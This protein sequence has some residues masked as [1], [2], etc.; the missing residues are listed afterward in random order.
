MCSQ[1]RKRALILAS[2][3]T[4]GLQSAVWA[5]VSI[6]SFTPGDLVVLRGGDTTNPST[7]PTTTL[8]AYLDEYTPAGVYQGTVG[9]PQAV[10]GSN[11][12]LTVTSG[13]GS[14]EGILTL[15][16][17]GNWLTFGGYNTP[18]T[19]AFSGAGVS[20]DTIAE[21]S[22]A[23]ATL[24]T[25]TTLGPATMRA[26]VTVDG[27]EFY[28][29]NAPGLQYVTGLGS[30][31]TTTAL[32]AAYNTRALLTVSNT[33][34]AGSGSSSLGTHGVWQLGSSGTLPTSG[35]PSKT[36]LTN[37]NIQDGTDFVF[38]DEPGD[39]LTNNLYQGKYNVM[40]SVG[41]ANGSATI[42]KYQ[43]DGTTFDLLNSETPVQGG[44][45]IL[46]GVTALV[47]GSNVNLYY[48][49]NSG[50]YKIVD[51]NSASTPLPNNG[52]LFYGAPAGQDFYGVALTP[53]A[54]AGSNS[55]T[56]NNTN[57]SGDGAT[58]NTTSQNWNNGTGVVAFSTSANVI[59]DDSSGLNHYTVNIASTG[60]TA[61]TITVNTNHS[62][63]YVFTG[64]G[65]IAGGQGLTLSAGTLTLA[66]TGVNTYGNTNVSAGR[67]NVESPTALPANSVLAVA[68]G[69]L[70]AVSRNGGA[71][72]VL[73]LNSLSNSGLIDLQNNDLI[74]HN[75]DTATAGATLSGVFNQLQAGYAGGTWNGT[76]GIVSSTAARSSLYTLGEATGTSGVDGTSV[77]TDVVVKY[78][79]YGDADLSGKIDSSD[80]TKIDN[81]YLSKLTGW[82]NGDFNYDG[83]VNGSDY[84]L[85]D[86]AF[87]SQGVSLA[88]QF[89]T[90]TSQI[91]GPVQTAVPEP[92][93]IGL[94][95]LMGTGA[96]ARRRTRC[97]LPGQ[98]TSLSIF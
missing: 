51:S 25:A 77:A 91:A 79:Y 89:A 57:G 64:S 92:A 6:S 65:G 56:W 68:A 69:A 39:T 47:S 44:G 10:S 38:A 81:G 98:A 95:A 35:T 50:L 80:Y 76:A 74:I 8:G 34:V 22:Q 9:I 26:V 43:Y 31:A 73:N 93:A 90:V 61:G 21:I 55:L 71:R 12:P 58:W 85:I 16:E 83:V 18:P 41:G 42:N 46:I 88:A 87:N 40:Y 23:V 82:S 72:I 2:L 32:S 52:T 30:A 60:V 4:A 84:T 1:F 11:N 36:L 27:N 75:P 48:T 14:H 15:S 59:F 24:N 96:L 53:T 37:G 67:L 29:S 49:D 70:V 78:T 66:N 94:L 28:V 17:N 20:N 7:G 97:R 5:D 19:T 86:N 63:G 45:D 33:L 62:G 13:P 54:I 3:A